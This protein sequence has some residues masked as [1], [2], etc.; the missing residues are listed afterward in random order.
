[1]GLTTK[2]NHNLLHPLFFS[3]LLLQVKI[4]EGEKKICCLPYKLYESIISKSQCNNN[5]KKAC[6]DWVLSC[7]AWGLRETLPTAGLAKM[8]SDEFITTWK[9]QHRMKRIQ[10][11]PDFPEKVVTFSSSIAM[12]G[13]GCALGM[14]APQ[15]AM[16][17]APPTYRRNH[18]CGCPKWL[19]QP[20][21]GA[22][23]TFVLWCL[24]YS[25]CTPL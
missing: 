9:G 23:Y 22:T 6:Q 17:V 11:K 12:V 15:C 4:T 20:V 10:L 14:Q 8:T 3:F 16:W 19:R 1:M 24:E 18:C 7:L 21:G 5:N 13:K 2:G 25:P